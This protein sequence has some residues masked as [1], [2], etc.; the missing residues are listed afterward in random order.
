MATSPK[1]VIVLPARSGENP[2]RLK[3]IRSAVQ[4]ARIKAFVV[5][6][7]LGGSAHGCS[8]LLAV[9]QDHPSD[10]LIFWPASVQPSAKTMSDMV[11]ASRDLDWV[12]ADRGSLS[13]PLGVYQSW[14]GVPALDLG[15]PYLVRAK[16][17]LALDQQL[18]RESPFLVARMVRAVMASGMSVG[19]LENSASESLQKMDALGLDLSQ[20]RLFF[21]GR[22]MGLVNS[23]LMVAAG[24]IMRSPAVIS[25]TLFGVGILGVGYY[26]GK[27]E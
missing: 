21:Q 13:G 9:A 2:L 22:G 23:G 26:L 6:V 15:A 7:P 17:L 24:L 14:L 12:F 25:L 5:E 19:S 3:Q 10:K 4:K 16:A 11:K 27:S 1:F 18:D 20:L 8:A